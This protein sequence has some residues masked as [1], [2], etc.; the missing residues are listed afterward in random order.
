MQQTTFTLEEEASKV[1]LL[2]NPAKCA[3][4]AGSNIELVNDLYAATS[5]IYIYIYIY[6]VIPVCIARQ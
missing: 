3:N 1:E 5:A 4:V 6:I 2:I